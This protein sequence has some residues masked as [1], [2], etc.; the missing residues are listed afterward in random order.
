MAAFP[1]TERMAVE[2]VIASV[3]AGSVETTAETVAVTEDVETGIDTVSTKA[4]GGVVETA[5]SD[6]ET[7]ARHD[8]QSR[9]LT[10]MMKDHHQ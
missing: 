9:M 3:I 5:S 1:R 4:N 10:Q 2:T 6:D 7:G 8:L